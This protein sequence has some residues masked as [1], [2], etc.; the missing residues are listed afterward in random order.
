MRNPNKIRFLNA[1]NHKQQSE[2]PLFEIEA[3][4]AIVNKMLGKRYD[5][6]LHSFELLPSEVIAW[7]REMGN[8]MVYFGHVWHLGRREKKDRE[9]RIHYIDGYMKTRESLKDLIFP[10][11]DLLEEKLEATCNLIQNSG[12]GLV[13]AAQ[14]AGF[15]VPTAIGYQDFCLGTLTNPEFIDDFQRYVHDYSMKELEMYM[16][17]PVDAV[18]ISSG[19]ITSNGSMISPD[20]LSKYEFHYIQ[21][22]CDLLKSAGIKTIFHID[23]EVTSWIPKFLEMG[24]DILNPID[25]SAEGQDIYD[26]KKK[27]GKHLTLHGNINIDGVLL[28]GNPKDVKSDVNTHIEKLAVGG[29]YVVASSHDLHQLIPVENIYTMRDAVHEYKC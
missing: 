6:G 12:F 17:Y 10:D 5:M 26:L 28:E 23:G 2:I 19:L 25:P 16:R 24:M 14:T 9:G 11:L 7:N 15:T 27:Y 18:K 21:E 29:G 1:V 13:C 22:Q 20:M 4:M 3:D 8:D